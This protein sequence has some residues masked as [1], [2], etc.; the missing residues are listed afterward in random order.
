M[1]AKAW[2]AFVLSRFWLA[3]FDHQPWGLM[4]FLADAHQ[5]GILRQ[6]GGVYQFRHARLQDH[7]A[8][9]DRT[10]HTAQHIGST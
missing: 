4:R 5:R 1:L 3:L 6:V 8:K 10:R 2:G 9:P 7:L